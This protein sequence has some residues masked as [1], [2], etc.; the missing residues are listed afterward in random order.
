MRLLVKL[1]FNSL[2]GEQI[3]KDIGQNSACKSEYWM[4]S[5][6]DERVKDYW[7]KS[8]GNFFV[9]M[10]DEKGLEDD[11]KKVNTMPLHLGVFVI[12]NSKSLMNNFVHAINAFY[13]NDVF[14]GDTDSLYIEK[15]TL[16]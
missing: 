6:Y 11:S 10:V 13:T 8:H 1:L 7:K 12:S 5:E 15:K 14:Y 4:L 16:G 3:R 9:K 2:F